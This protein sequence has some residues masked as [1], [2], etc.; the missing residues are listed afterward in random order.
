MHVLSSTILR[1]DPDHTNSM[2]CI[3]K[4]EGCASDGLDLVVDSLAT[5]V[6]KFELGS[7]SSDEK[8]RLIFMHSL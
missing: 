1:A 5:R 4:A 3:V 8:R 6:G 7:G 2:I